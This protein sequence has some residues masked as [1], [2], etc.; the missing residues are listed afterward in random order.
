MVFA[1]DELSPRRASSLT[2]HEG[3]LVGRSPELERRRNS[4]RT[5]PTVDELSLAV[6]AAPLQLKRL[7]D[8][9][10]RVHTEVAWCNHE[11]FGDPEPSDD[12][13]QRRAGEAHGA[14]GV[15]QIRSTAQ[16]GVAGGGG[17]LPYLD[18]IQAAFGKHDV[19]AIG[20]HV[21]GAARTA[22]EAIGAEAYATGTSVAFR[23]TPDLHTAAHEAAHVVQQR[24]GVALAGGVGAAGDTYERHADAVADAVVRGRSAEGLLDG[25]SGAGGGGAVQRKEQDKGKDTG[26]GKA[27]PPAK[28]PEFA[29]GKSFSV[30]P[31]KIVVKGGS[32]GG[33]VAFTLA[34]GDKAYLPLMTGVFIEL[35]VE[36]T[37]TGR[38]TI[39]KGRIEAQVGAE[40][41][42]KVLLSGG[43]PGV[44]KIGG[45]GK[46]A[47][48]ITGSFGYDTKTGVW[49]PN[50]TLVIKAGPVVE[51]T[52]DALGAA[53]FMG[54]TWGEWVKKLAADRAKPK[55]KSK[56]GPLKKNAGLSFEWSPGGMIE[57]A[58]YDA[59]SGKWILAPSLA[60]ALKWLRGNPPKRERSVAVGVLG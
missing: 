56:K 50:L 41:A 55:D 28:A 42:A 16:R 59:R 53:D 57:I 60:K 20:A 48:T 46:G 37:V 8:A 45:G 25:L 33:E 13:V 12:A 7:D 40:L 14:G 44:A 31:C 43:I 21:G 51:A 23:T 32:K 17:A 6:G 47:A 26:K 11:L 1:R 34:K 49:T 10:S 19:S 52:F 15:A 58:R 38:G 3:R 24:A 29:A 39:T 30:G 54:K 4:D 18:V 22:A 9:V 36:G 5:R 2:G 27:K 35:A